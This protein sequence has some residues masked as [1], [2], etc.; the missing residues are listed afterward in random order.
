[1]LD[2]VCRACIFLVRCVRTRRWLFYLGGKSVFLRCW[3]TIIDIPKD[4]IDFEG[5]LA[6]LLIRT[7]TFKAEL[8]HAFNIFGY[9]A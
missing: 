5:V 7:R 8:L 2:S 1:M 3:H 6:S 9:N 4:L